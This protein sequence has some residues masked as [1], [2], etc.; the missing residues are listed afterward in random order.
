MTLMV[1]ESIKLKS[2]FRRLGDE[3]DEE[4][5]ETLPLDEELDEDKDSGDDSSD[6]EEF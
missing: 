1:E 2:A 4:K 6:E 5:T 3:E